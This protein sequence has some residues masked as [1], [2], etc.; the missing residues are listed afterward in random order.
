MQWGL[1]MESIETKNIVIHCNGGGGVL[2]HPLI[3]LNLG[4]EE[5][6]ICPYCRRCFHKDTNGSFE[7]LPKNPNFYI[8]ERG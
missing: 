6:V 8:E 4:K 5:Q 3:Y 2:G 7:E 1:V